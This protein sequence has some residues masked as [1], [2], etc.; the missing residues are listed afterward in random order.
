MVLNYL[1]SLWK[2][3]YRCADR[4]LTP[5]PAVPLRTVRRGTDRAD[6]EGNRN[7]TEITV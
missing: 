7:R 5:R 2:V 1:A 6:T 4:L 3:L